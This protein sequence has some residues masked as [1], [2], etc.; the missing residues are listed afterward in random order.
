MTDV[1]CLRLQSYMCVDDPILSANNYSVMPRL[2][3]V[4]RSLNIAKT[5]R[6]GRKLQLLVEGQNTGMHGGISPCV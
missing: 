3:V 6:D 2:E 1:V 4:R 5:A